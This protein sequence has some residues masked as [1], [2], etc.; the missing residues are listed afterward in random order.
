MASDDKK[1]ETSSA[2]KN[3]AAVKEDT[4]EKEKRRGPADKD[5]VGIQTSPRLEGSEKA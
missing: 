1:T 2:P 3:E 5:K 4:D